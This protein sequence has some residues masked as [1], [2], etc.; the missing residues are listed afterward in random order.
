MSE[1]KP[2]FW[3]QYKDDFKMSLE[4]DLK[5]AEEKRLAKPTTMEELQEQSVQKQVDAVYKNAEEVRKNGGKYL[6]VD[7]NVNILGASGNA[8]AI[9]NDLFAQGWT[10]LSANGSET[11]VLGSPFTHWHLVFEDSQSKRTSK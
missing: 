3:Q 6:V 11:V 7:L 2:G 5:A 8:Q 4:R 1:N 9:M 10:L